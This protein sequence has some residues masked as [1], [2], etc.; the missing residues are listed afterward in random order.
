[1]KV[2]VAY[3]MHDYWRDKQGAV[4]STVGTVLGCAWLGAG[5]RVESLPQS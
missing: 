3:W 1:M 2:P 5:S 4:R